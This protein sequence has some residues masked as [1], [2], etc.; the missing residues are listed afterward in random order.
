M[1]YCLHRYLSLRPALILF[2]SLNLHSAGT[3]FSC[4]SLCGPKGDTDLH[5]RK[6]CY[7]GLWQVKHP[8]AVI[9]RPVMNEADGY[10]PILCPKDSGRSFPS[11]DL[12]GAFEESIDHQPHSRNHE[13]MMS[14][15]PVSRLLHN[16]SPLL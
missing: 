6:F 15:C 4:T 5:S 7:P 11:W 9:T 14:M 12:G 10:K 2:S 1:S 8:C 13:F 16:T 3:H